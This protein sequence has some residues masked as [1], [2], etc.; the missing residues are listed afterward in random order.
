MTLL[1][2]QWMREI[3]CCKKLLILN[4]H[5]AT[6]FSHFS[7]DAFSARTTVPHASWQCYHTNDLPGGHWGWDALLLCRV[8]GG[9]IAP[10]ETLYCR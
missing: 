6:S 5:T 10:L 2:Q 7:V 8:M 1:D 3:Q 4:R 9:C